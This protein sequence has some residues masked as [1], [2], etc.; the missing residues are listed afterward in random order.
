MSSVVFFGNNKFSE[1]SP[2]S[3]KDLQEVVKKNSKLLFGASTIY[4]DL[5]PR[6]ETKA[7]GGSIPDGLLFDLKDIDS[8]EFYLVEVELEKHDFYRHIF[9]QITR[10]F[11]FFRNQKSQSALI[12]K[13]FSAIQSD[14]ALEA[15]FKK[16]LKG[17][18]I[19]KFIKDTVEDSQNILLIIDE[20]KPELPEM[21]DTYTEWSKMVRIVVLKQYSYKDST[22]L[23]LTPGF[24][25]IEVAEI[26]GERKGEDKVPY[27]EEYHLDGV[28]PRVKAAYEAIKAGM[29]QFKPTLRFNPQKYYI[30][31]V[32]K[33]NSSYITV[34]KKKLRITVMLPE[35][36]VR[37]AIKQHG[38]KTLSE[39][40]RKFY[41][42]GGQSCRVIV[43]DEANI[44]EVIQVLKMAVT[45]M[46]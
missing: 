22:M 35:A 3:E 1:T 36:T 32:D 34:R 44:G 12:E 43:E 6:I 15:E 19:F 16:F 17:R 5:K 23:A 2:D 14:K 33:K 20:M 31:I 39:G 27:T 24:E 40:V 9:P 10:F 38:V 28:N 29:L 13:T 4:I 37:A 18:E 25:G 46:K 41:G 26:A 30:S 11:A 8:P 42:A 45:R 7:I 21:V